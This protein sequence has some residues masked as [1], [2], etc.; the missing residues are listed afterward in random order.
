MARTAVIITDLVSARDNQAGGGLNA[1]PGAVAVDP[2]NGHVIAGAFAKND[3]LLLYV[4][5]TTVSSKTLTL[6]A[7]VQPPSARASLGDVVL[8]LLATTKYFIG[9]LEAAQFAQADGS[10]FVGIQAAMTGNIYAVRVKR[11]V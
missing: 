3:E 9:P 6:K 2:T 11:D 10:L 7:G 4:D 8:T 5:H 1:L